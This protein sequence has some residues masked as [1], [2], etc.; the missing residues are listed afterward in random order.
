MIKNAHSL[1][2]LIAVATAAAVTAIGIAVPAQAQAAPIS[3]VT[4]TNSFEG[5]PWNDWQGLK[6]GDGVAGAD[7]NGNPVVARTGVNNGWLYTGTGWAAEKIAVSIGSWGDR[8]NCSASIWANPVSYGAGVGLEVWDPNGANGWV[9]LTSTAPG[10]SA[11][12]YQQI[13]TPPLNLNGLS[14]VYIQAIYGNSKAVAQFV[15]ID[16]VSLTCVS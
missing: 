15:R 13:T 10:V 8:S 12:K 6:S 1:L 5:N 3:T 16:D 2:R 11:G 7:V 14:T 9:K 4:F